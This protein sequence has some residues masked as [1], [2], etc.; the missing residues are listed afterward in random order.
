MADK[1]KLSKNSSE[2]L[3]FLS[4]RLDFKRNIVC[5]MALCVSLNVRE[6]V[7]RY[8]ESDTDG[9]EFNKSTII[10][11]DE[12]LFKALSSYVQNEPSDSDFFNII[13]R[14][15]IERG[16]KILYDDYQTINS[17][18]EF[19]VSLIKSNNGMDD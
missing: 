15:H 9:Y 14:N 10:G 3:N 8:M 13:V 1:L 4:T 16:L 7:H 6:P 12:T 19:M 11:P 18:V 5:R 2:Y 17:P